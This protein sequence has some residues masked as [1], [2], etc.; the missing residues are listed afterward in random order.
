M[1]ADTIGYLV[2]F[3][4]VLTVLIFVHELGHYWVARR[5][6]IRVEVFSIG[7]GP[8]LWAREDRHGTRWRIAAIPIGGYVKF[9]GDADAA[10]YGQ[11]TEGLTEAEKAVAFPFK[12]LSARAA[13]VAAGPIANFLFAIVAFAIL[14]MTWGLPFTAPVVGAVQ[15]GSAAEA[16][17]LR[18]G[19]RFVE[20][21]GSAIERFQDVQRIV[22]FR[23]GETLA[24]VMEREGER[25]ALRAVPKRTTVTDGFGRKQEIGLLGVSQSGVEMRRYGPG[26]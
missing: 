6:G 19:D 20:V 12:P 9:F 1:I 23:P 4:V 22:R 21:E 26:M 17:G 11:A 7:F 2:P 13:V 25:L 15:P 16:A 24:L 3:L 5:C 18:P 10:S 8:E 14:A